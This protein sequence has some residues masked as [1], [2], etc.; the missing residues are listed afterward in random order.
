MSTSS[1]DQKNALERGKIFIAETR[2]KVEQL[3]D[4]FAEGKLNREQFQKL[5][6]RYQLQISGVRSLLAEADPS[7]WVEAIDGERTI[8]IRSRLMAKAV[9]M[10]IYNNE[11]GTL[12]DRLGLF[13]ADPVF[14]SNMMEKLANQDSNMPANPPQLVVQEAGGEWVLLMKGELTTI[15]MT[16]SREPT[17]EQKASVFKLLKDFERANVLILQR[18]NIAP[19]QLAMPFRVIIQQAGRL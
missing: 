18:P 11:T 16:F 2:R 14:V 6:E 3:A 8:D 17:A 19:D 13:L 1:T 12:L 15:A 4:D 10:L 5:Y 7:R 9:G